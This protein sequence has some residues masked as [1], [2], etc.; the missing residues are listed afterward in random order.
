MSYRGWYQFL[1][2]SISGK[3][4]SV[5]AISINLFISCSLC[6]TRLCLPFSHF[7]LYSLF[8]FLFVKEDPSPRSCCIHSSFE[9]TT[10]WFSLFILVPGGNHW[11]VP[12]TTFSFSF[13]PLY[14][15]S[16]IWFYPSLFFSDLILA[17]LQRKFVS[18][19]FKSPDG[20]Q[21]LTAVRIV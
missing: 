16:S 8:S 21:L 6:L 7:L 1:S 19:N 4:I 3:A 20:I 10:A 13:F 2:Y 5:Q 9:Y 11:R 18:P 15:F 17:F 14:P 12:W